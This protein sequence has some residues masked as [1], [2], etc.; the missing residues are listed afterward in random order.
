MRFN[1][2]AI[3]TPDGQA[4]KRKLAEMPEGGSGKAFAAE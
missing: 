3:L 4:D 2:L 1:K